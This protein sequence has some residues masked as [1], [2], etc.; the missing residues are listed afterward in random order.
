M[1]IRKKSPPPPLLLYRLLSW[2]LFSILLMLHLMFGHE[3]TKFPISAKKP[4]CY[5]CVFLE[6]RI[7]SNAVFWQF[8]SCPQ[9]KRGEPAKKVLGFFKNKPKITDMC[10]IISFETTPTQNQL[11]QA[12]SQNTQPSTLLITPFHLK[13]QEK[14]QPLWLVSMYPPD[15]RLP[16][17]IDS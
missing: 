10:G 5:K 7:Y 15:L 13:K 14:N 8:F 16:Q 9:V 4:H 3:E 11:N 2:A 17:R 12:Y 1:T 6:K